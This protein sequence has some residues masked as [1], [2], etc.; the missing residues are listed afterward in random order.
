MDRSGN[1]NL[2]ALAA[3]LPED[4]ARLVAAGNFALAEKIIE[5]RLAK[6]LPT[7]LRERLLLEQ[8][9]L[10]QLPQQ[11]PYRWAE[12][13]AEMRQVFRD[14]RDEE[15]DV[16]LEEGA[17]EWI[18]LEGQIRIKDD[19][20]ANLIKTREELADRVLD[21]ALIQ[22]KWDN[23]KMLD[24]IIETMETAGSVRCRFRIRSTIALH[25]DKMRPAKRIQVQLPLPIEYAQVKAFRLLSCEPEGAKLAPAQ[26][27][28][29]TICFETAYREGQTFSVE[30]EFETEARYWDWRAAM[31]CAERTDGAAAASGAGMRD[32]LSQ[33]LPHIRFTP[34]L[35]ALT[36]EIIGAETDALKKAKKIYDYITTHVMYSF[37]RSYFTIPQQVTFTATNLKGDCG[38]QAL[39]FI[40]LCRIA[41]V[42]ARWQS[43]LYANPLTIGCHDWAQFYVEP[44]GWLFA[45]CSFGG[46]AYRAGDMKRWDFFFGNLEPYRL[47]AA[48]EYQGA[49]CFPKHYL[50]HDPYDNQMGEVEYE[51]MGLL[52]G[53][54]FNTKHEVL[55]LRVTV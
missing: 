31:E 33:Q 10:A 3:E 14:F 20:I 43:G 44:Y 21:R 28:Q 27:A 5:R 15:L 50:R 32:Y 47:P 8:E 55:E 41:Q 53:V 48:C 12:A 51:D 19:F 13:A 25:E 6:E 7:M 17:F 18:Y 30:Y 45:D 36:A 52:H 24:Q 23:F 49:F 38:L 4:I 9:I 26:C 42:P 11:Y 35:E 54:D 2:T 46:A 1:Q 34:Y 37:V 39:L 22:G 16:F 29:R 40:T